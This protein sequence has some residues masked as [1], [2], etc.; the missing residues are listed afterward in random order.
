MPGNGKMGSRKTAVRVIKQIKNRH[1]YGGRTR[2]GVVL[3]GAKPAIPEQMVY[4]EC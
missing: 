1:N 3:T 4:P 2:L